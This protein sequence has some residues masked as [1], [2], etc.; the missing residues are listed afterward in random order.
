[1]LS[2]GIPYLALVWSHGRRGARREPARGLLW[3]LPARLLFSRSA[4]PLFLGS[5][6][7]LAFL[8][9]GLWDAFVWRDHPG[10]FHAFMSLPRVTD[11]AVLA[12]LV[13]LLALP[14][15]THYLLDGFLWK[16]RDSSEA[17]A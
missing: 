13:P 10:I 8:E 12:W 2:H 17:T 5:L 9:E 1:V 4:L 14:Q 11:R 6:V 15:I 3:G 16:R 7:T